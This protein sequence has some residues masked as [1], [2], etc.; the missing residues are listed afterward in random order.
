VSFGFPML[1]Y[2]V[3]YYNWWLVGAGALIIVVGLTGWAL[4]PSVAE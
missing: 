4:E 1:G 3:I 2:G